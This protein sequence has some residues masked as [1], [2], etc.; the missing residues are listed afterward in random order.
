MLRSGVSLQVTATP[1]FAEL[2]APGSLV[3]I[4]ADAA[5]ATGATATSLLEK[6]YPPEVVAAVNAAMGKSDGDPSQKKKREEA[7]EEEVHQALQKKCDVDEE[8]LDKVS[9]CLKRA[10]LLKHMKYK[11]TSHQ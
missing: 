4:A 6:G 5:V 9:N 3:S 7:T 11:A 2:H 1:S 10:M 8:D